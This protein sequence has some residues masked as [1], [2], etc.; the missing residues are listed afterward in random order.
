MDNVL[1]GVNSIVGGH[2]AK[3][4][5]KFDDLAYKRLLQSNKF[6]EELIRSHERIKQELV[7]LLWENFEEVRK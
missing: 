1:I 5:G 4:I 2:S 7:E 3:V 6:P